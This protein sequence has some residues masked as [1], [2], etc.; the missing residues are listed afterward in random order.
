MKPGIFIASLI[1]VMVTSTKLFSQ[2][3]FKLPANTDLNTAADYKRHETTV[4][5]ASKWLEESPL[6]KFKEDRSKLNAFIITWASGP[7]VNVSLKMKLMMLF[8]DNSDLLA[9]YMGAF[10]RYCI[11]NN[12]KDGNAAA[13]AGFTAAN[14]V[15]NKGVGVKK[16]ASLDAMS[17]QIADG[18]IEE[19]VKEMGK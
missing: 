18:K 16:N 5:K 3:G 9:I 7:S 1:L 15:Y 11:E 13:K 6:D 14:N 2:A 19:F 12:V 4:V 17:K 10:C 8:K